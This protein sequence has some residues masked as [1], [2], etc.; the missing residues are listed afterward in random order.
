[1]VR[2]EK[3]HDISKFEDRSS[4]L[5]NLIEQTYIQ[6]LQLQSSR[7][8]EDMNLLGAMACTTLRQHHK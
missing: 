6:A 5:K 1:M 7:L 2:I 8:L 4:R 3:L